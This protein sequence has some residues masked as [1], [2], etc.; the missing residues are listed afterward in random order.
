M[1]GALGLD[2]QE[3]FIVDDEVGDEIAK[4][5]SPKEYGEW[6]TLEHAQTIRA[7]CDDHG[8]LTNTLEEPVAKFRVDVVVDADDAFRQLPMQQFHLRGSG[9]ERSRRPFAKRLN[10]I[11]GHRSGAWKSTQSVKRQ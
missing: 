11:A 10:R 4:Q 6:D 8:F 7:E 1:N 2:F 5:L 9:K 3:H